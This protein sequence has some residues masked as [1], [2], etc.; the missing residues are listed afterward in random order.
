ME[1]Q[2][3]TVLITGATGGIG[4]SVCAAYAEAGWRI[5]GHCRTRGAGSESLAAGLQDKTEFRLVEADLSLRD[6][7]ES[8][9]DQVQGER[10]DALVNNA[11]GYVAPKR[12]DDLTMEDLEATFALNAFSPMILASRLFSG[13]AERGFGRIV[14]ISSIAAK[15]GGGALS[16]DYGCAKRALEGSMKTLARE[17]AQRNVLVNCVRP[18]FIDTEAHRKHP[19]DVDARIRL[20][21]MRRPGQAEEV[22]GLVVFLGSEANTFVTNEIWAVA[23]GE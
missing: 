2:T 10:V 15:Y 20:I 19:K 7:V 8:L 13:M 4:R 22:A 3:R 1:S 9:L 5:L 21:P 14:N 16:M 12:F 17:G 23:G 6:G 11:G 18:G